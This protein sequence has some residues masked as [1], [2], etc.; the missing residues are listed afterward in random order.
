MAPLNDD[1]W[2]SMS[3]VPRPDERRIEGVSN[4]ELWNELRYIRRK[5]DGLESKVL[6]LFGTISAISVTVVIYEL[7][8]RSGQV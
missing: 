8:S 3:Y 2:W 1:E 4:A 6:T 5:V 7:L